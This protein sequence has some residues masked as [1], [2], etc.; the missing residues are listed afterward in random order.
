MLSFLRFNR[1]KRDQKRRRSTTSWSPTLESLEELILLSPTPRRI[2]PPTR[3]ITRPIVNLVIPQKGSTVYTNPT[4]STLTLTANARDTRSGIASVQFL[5]DGRSIAKTTTAPYSISW[6]TKNISGR[7]TIKVVARDGAGNVRT[8]APVVV[9]FVLDK[10][11]PSVTLNP[12]PLSVS[13]VQPLTAV[14]R[15]TK[16]GGIASVQFLLDGYKSLGIA[17]TA[18]Y[19]IWWDTTK[20]SPG[21]HSLTAVAR[22][23]AGNV[24]TSAVMST[25][26]LDTPPTVS[27][28]S[29]PSSV[30]GT[31]I[32]TANASDTQ[33]GI[34][35][36]QFLVDGQPLATVTAAPYT[37][38][39]NTTS[40]SNI[41]HTLTAIAK[42]GAGNT[43]TSAPVTVTVLDTTSPTV[44]LASLPPSVS[45]TQILTA[46]ASDTQSGIASVQFL[47]DG[48][49]LA[50]VTAAPY[51]FSWNTTS[52][53]NIQHTLTAIA[54]DGAGNTATS[55]PVTV[56][57]LDTT[58]PTV[59]LASPPSS[60]SGTQILTANASDT[61]SGIASVQFLVDGQPLATVTAAP[62]TFSWDTTSV[63]NIQHTLTVIAKDG[64]GNTATSAPVTVTVVNTV[65]TPTAIPV[66][67]FHG[68]GT[69][70][71]NFP[72]NMPL[73]TFTADMTALHDAGYH[74]ITLQQY[75]D[76]EAGKNPVLP[77]KPIL[78]TNDDGDASTMQMTSVLQSY[79][80]TM[81][82]FIVT[83]F[84][85]NGNP[86]NVTWAQLQSMV[87]SGTWEVAF[88]AGA[89]GHY[90]YSTNPPPGQ[91]LEPSAPYFYADMF[92]EDQASDALYQQ[93][94]TTEL[95]QGRARAQ[96]D[97]PL[98][99][100]QCIRSAL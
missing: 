13:G 46:N 39:W 11:P 34:A 98:C 30:S 48:Q 56:T 21:P 27:L 17:T 22:D 45:G 10:T 19:T 93:R 66:I 85:D 68:I 37:F 44:N 8:S 36:V 16:G 26:V 88:H 40:V 99:V 70:P 25:T 65:V 50:T 52:V 4:A 95:D 9:K 92:P 29:L 82:A 55:A 61:Q 28:A 49:P 77:S 15:D 75:L 79:G 57:V 59:S 42:D 41:Q 72:Y 96:A 80:Y 62:Y 12:P 53:S 6:N 33:S 47:V 100:Y 54:K 58:P 84:I 32:L 91:P 73:S 89:D 5:V 38:S 67:A 63:S 18:P 1:A 3:D 69:D 51:T 81:V 87:A 35:S 71:A 97:D 14:A 78:L 43:A 60:V 94:V 24:R 76:W 86:F 7:H 2:L 23:V 31:Q 20:E 90:D 83:G 64:A 74:S